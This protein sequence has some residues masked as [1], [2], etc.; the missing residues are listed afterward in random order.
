LL[1]TRVGEDAFTRQ[2][3]F[4]TDL[5]WLRNAKAPSRFQL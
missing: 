4:E 2:S 3:L 5:A 1:I